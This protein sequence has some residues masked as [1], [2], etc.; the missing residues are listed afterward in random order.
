MTIQERLKRQRYGDRTVF[1][2][3]NN[4][5]KHIPTNRNLRTRLKKDKVYSRIL[6]IFANPPKRDKYYQGYMKVINDYLSYVPDASK[7]KSVTYL[8]E[9]ILLK[10][11]IYFIENKHRYEHNFQIYSQSWLYGALC[12]MRKY[13]MYH[14]MK[15]NKIPILYDITSPSSGGY[16]SLPKPMNN[17]AMIELGDKL[18]TI[19]EPYLKYYKG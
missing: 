8:V 19:L 15:E 16:Y 11:L 2:P 1:M 9:H 13:I 14:L 10:K 4:E 12:S 7:N 3:N 6:D 18:Y 17:P 5:I